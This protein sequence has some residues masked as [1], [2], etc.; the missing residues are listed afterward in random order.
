MPSS[1][2][3]PGRRLLPALGALL[4]AFAIAT[5]LLPAA[6]A[7]AAD[8]DPTIGVATRP[9]G[10][11]GRPDGRT[12]FSYSA[13]PGQTVTD[14]VLVGNTGTARQDFTVYATDAY[15]S[16]DGTLSLLAT[17]ETPVSLGA[18]VRFDNGADRIQFSLE[19]DEVRLLTF[20]VQF[21]ADATPGDHVGGLVASVVEDGQQVSLDRRVA[22]AMF[23]RVAGEVQPRLTVTSF[24]AAYQGDWW[25]PFGGTVKIVYTVT[26]PGNVALAANVSMSVG[27]W[28]GIPATGDRGGSIPVLLPG[29]TAT[30]QF[31]V[32]GVGQWGYLDPAVTLSPFVDAQD[33]ALQLLV[34]SVTRDTFV[35]AVPWTLLILIALAVGVYFL[36]RW[37]RRRDEARAQE[38]IEYTEQ[39]AAAAAAEKATVS[40][41]P[42]G[43]ADDS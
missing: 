36:L 38:W 7:V 31:E 25:N 30:Y 28:F 39:Q 2:W 33:P 20:T 16:P 29:N 12:R 32:P 41:A 43:K 35:F 22:T 21:P 14:Q 6:S 24:D 18:W 26:N 19:P 17:A 3:R 9:A 10:S 37:R 34:P 40:A 27:T 4:L 15:N 5:P 11:D 42:A 13:D 1:T 8:G 23:A